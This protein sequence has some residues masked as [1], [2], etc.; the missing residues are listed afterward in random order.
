MIL[1]V[2]ARFTFDGD[3][4]VATA[5]AQYQVRALSRALDLLNAFS[6]A[7][8]ELSLAAIAASTHLA[9]STALRLLAILVDY[10]LVE[11]S[12][13]TD[14]YRIGVRLFELGSIYIQATSIE[15][16]ALPLM[17]TLARE[18]HQTANLGI[19]DRGE[20][21]HLAVVPPE[22]P[23]RFYARVGQR[24][25]A[26]CTGLGKAL[27]AGL[28]ESEVEQL[29]A[30]RSLTSR[31][32]RTIVTIAALR[33]HLAGVRAQGV[34]LD[35]EE[36]EV[37]LKCVAAPIHDDRN[38]TIAAVSIS[39]PAAEFSEQMLPTYVQ[40]VKQAAYDISARLG[41]GVQSGAPAALDGAER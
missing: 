32:D 20:V 35:N 31:T 16:E 4:R 41:N 23:I 18:C 40:A 2:E 5:Q 26:H 36:A 37:G 28:T 15:A 6:L 19:L 3:D 8:P 39:G 22:R 33:A 38:R 11:K 30:Q 21:V 9:P 27:L 34:A 14:R 1:L 29:V 25:S 12:A 10:G 24:E 17:Q 7:Q 13:E